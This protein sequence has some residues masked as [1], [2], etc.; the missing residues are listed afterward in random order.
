MSMTRMSQLEKPNYTVMIGNFNAKIGIF[1][2]EMRNKR[3]DNL[4]KWV[5]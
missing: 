3:E 2:L 4:V 5:K 1:G